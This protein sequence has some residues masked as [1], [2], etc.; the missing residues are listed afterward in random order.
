MSLLGERKANADQQGGNLRCQHIKLP[1][2]T[3]SEMKVL[4]REMQSGDG[5]ASKQRAINW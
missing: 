3:N 4:F 2:L 1:V 5:E